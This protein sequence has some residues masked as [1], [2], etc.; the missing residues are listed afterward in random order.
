MWGDNGVPATGQDFFLNHSMKSPLATFALRYE[1][2]K[3]AYEAGYSAA[4]L[5]RDIS[6]TSIQQG[7]ASGSG[8][9]AGS[10]GVGLSAVALNPVIAARHRRRKKDPD[11][12]RR[13]M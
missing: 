12:P 8:S 7:G 13:N 4:F 2:Q 1:Q 6:P 5:R 11:M 3:Q 10:S 9:G